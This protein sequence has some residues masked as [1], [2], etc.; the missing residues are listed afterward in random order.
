MSHSELST[1][2]NKAFSNATD[3]VEHLLV[4]ARQLQPA[5]QQHLGIVM[6]MGQALTAVFT[7][8]SE[9]VTVLSPLIL[10]A[11]A[12]LTEH[13]DDN[14]TGLISP[15]VWSNIRVDDPRIKG[16][17]LSS[18]TLQYQQP[19][20]APSPPTTGPSIQHQKSKAVITSDD[21]HDLNEP[22]PTIMP[23]QLTKAVA[24]P[25]AHRVQ[26]QSVIITSNDELD[27]NEPV[28]VGPPPKMG[29]PY[30]ALPP[31]PKTAQGSSLKEDDFADTDAPAWIPRCGQ[32]VTHDLVSCQAFNKDHS[33]KL[34]VCGLCS[35]LKIKCGGQ[36]SE[37]PKAKGESVTTRRGHSQSHRHPISS[38]VVK[39]NEVVATADEGRPVPSSIPSNPTAAIAATGTP[40]QSSP[41][42][43]EG[44]DHLGIQAL[45]EEV[46]TLRTAVATLQDQVVAGKQL[47]PAVLQPSESLPPPNE[48]TLTSSGGLDSQPPST[49]P[50][51]EMDT[52]LAVGSSTDPSLELSTTL[53]G[54]AEILEDSA[55][56]PIMPIVS[57]PVELLDSVPS[58]V[59]ST[60][61]LPVEESAM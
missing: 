50:P 3:K 55:Q 59:K 52:Q 1:A 43:S 8:Y 11:S 41:S 4:Q 51:V 10:S 16:H 27:A 37:A 49:E 15:P 61:S 39:D 56:L 44:H 47:L 34:K 24:K 58:P 42:G 30:V 9:G 45:Q 12:E 36:G 17:L 23:G 18:L 14:G 38:K 21:D 31:V 22:G 32:C 33:G 54:T 57:L 28:K 40:T 48:S 13:L 60:A 46:A 5:D 53:A 19:A 35:R 7:K 26:R 25:K 6:E 2:A 29:P 20:P